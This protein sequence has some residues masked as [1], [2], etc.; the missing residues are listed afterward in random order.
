MA[1]SKVLKGL[2]TEDTI[3]TIDSICTQTEI[4]K[5]EPRTGRGII[6]LR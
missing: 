4:A 2:D 5:R 1:I 3:V 6:N